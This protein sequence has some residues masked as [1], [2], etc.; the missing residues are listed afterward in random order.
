MSHIRAKAVCL[1]R[2]K[3]KVL[4]AAG[5]D[6][7]TDEHYLLPIG[8][9]IEF[10][11]TSAQ[12]AQREVM[13]EIGAE[14]YDLRL[15]GVLENLFSFNGNSGHEIVFVYEAQ[16]VNKSLYEQAELR[17]VESNGIEFSVRWFDQQQISGYALN[18]YPSGISKMIW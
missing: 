5:Y 16:F 12:A 17:A 14:I 8:G 13:E 15:L 18:I 7:A 1:F 10:G 3:N 6:P 2:Y 4:L 9:G 11:E